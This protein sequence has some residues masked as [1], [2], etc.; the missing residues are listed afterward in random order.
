M[1]RLDEIGSLSVDIDSIA[2]NGELYP[3]IKVSSATV[4]TPTSTRGF[5]DYFPEKWDHAPD[6]Y[7]S[8]VYVREDR[9]YVFVFK[10]ALGWYFRELEGHEEEEDEIWSIDDI[11]F[12]PCKSMNECFPDPKEETKRLHST[13][14]SIVLDFTIIT[15]P[16]QLHDNFERSVR[17]TQIRL[18]CYR[19]VVHKK[20][21][22]S[23]PHY[24]RL[25]FPRRLKDHA[26]M[27]LYKSL[28]SNNDDDNDE[29]G[30]DGINYC[31]EEK[32]GDEKVTSGTKTE[33]TTSAGRKNR[34]SITTQRQPLIVR[35]MEEPREK[36]NRRADLNKSIVQLK[37]AQSLLKRVLRSQ[38]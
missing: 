27:E 7:S 33:T 11:S 30:D 1:S 31:I 34:T 22:D 12:C 8:I 17:E 37:E 15:N 24:V 13:E 29:D 19:K 16:V 35:L 36:A 6:A 2:E 38:R 9:K 18:W 23:I 20:Y 21:C 14:N 28:L 25:Q 26:E 10:N 5:G 32:G 3:M 4:P